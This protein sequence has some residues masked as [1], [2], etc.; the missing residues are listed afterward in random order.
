MA[1]FSMLAP[2]IFVCVML[3]FLFILE[4]IRKAASA[5]SAGIEK[6][7]DFGRFAGFLGPFAKLIRLIQFLVIVVPFLLFIYNFYGYYDSHTLKTSDGSIRCWPS[8][9]LKCGAFEANGKNLRFVFNVTDNVSDIFSTWNSDPAMGDTPRT[10]VMHAVS[11][12]VPF[13]IGK[14]GPQQTILCPMKSWKYENRQIIMNLECAND[15]NAGLVDKNANS[16]GVEWK[17]EIIGS[18]QQSLS[19]QLSDLLSIA[20]G[21]V[22]TLQKY[23]ESQCKEI[24]VAQFCAVTIG[25]EIHYNE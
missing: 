15:V 16:I 20:T 23:Y 5:G 10:Y 8:G 17:L 22:I 19:A 7:D 6:K 4:F 25:A 21:D 13:Y 18:P 14:G 12:N 1:Q 24:G 9:M 11:A 2:F 3:I